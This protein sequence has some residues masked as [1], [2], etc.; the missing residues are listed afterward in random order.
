M[1]LPQKPYLPLG[2]L[3]NALSYPHANGCGV[4]DFASVLERCGLAHL[5][6][7]LEKDDNWAH[8]LSLGEQQRLAF[9]RILLVKP[10]FVFLDEATASVDEKSEADLYREL[11]NNLPCSAVVSVGHRNTLVSWHSEALT[12]Q[13][14][15]NWVKSSL[16]GT[17]LGMK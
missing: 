6:P 9:A 8:V 12:F 14:D 7:D 4:E 17:S 13:G 2:T 15:A 3:S 11:Q 16:A 10:D 1:F 5:I